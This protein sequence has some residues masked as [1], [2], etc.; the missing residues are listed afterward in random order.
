[1][2][3][4]EQVIRQY[5]GRLAEAQRRGEAIRETMAGLRVTERSA[6]GQ[7]AVTVNDAG[8]LVDLHLGSALQ[9]KDGQAVAQEVLRVV[10]AAQS[11]VAAAVQE[12]MTPLLG[13]DSQAMEFMVDRLR[14]AQPPPPAPPGDGYGA[15]LRFG[16]AEDDAPPPLPPPQPPRHPRPSPPRHQRPDDDDFSQGGFLR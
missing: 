12:A 13:G 11:R 2:T 9:R 10:Q 8:N 7:I 1:M 3:D 4:P 15:E 6:D 16:P 5:E 14:S